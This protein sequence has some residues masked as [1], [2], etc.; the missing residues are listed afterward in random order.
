MIHNNLLRVLLKGISNECSGSIG[1]A[2]AHENLSDEAINAI[3]NAWKEYD[4]NLEC[5]CDEIEK[6]AMDKTQNSPN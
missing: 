4:K 2:V 3:Y 5:V 6:A 1:K